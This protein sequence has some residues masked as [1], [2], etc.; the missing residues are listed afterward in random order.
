MHKAFILID[1]TRFYASVATQFAPHLRQVPLVVTTHSAEKG[2]PIALNRA[3]S[4]LGV[5]KFAPL[6]KGDTMRR[7]R[8]NNALIVSANFDTFGHASQRFMQSAIA[9]AGSNV[10]DGKIQHM[11]YSVDE[12][13]VSVDVSYSSAIPWDSYAAEIR[14]RVWREQRIGS[15]V[16]IA[17]TLTLS[18]S[19]SFA[20]KKMDGFAGTCVI[21]DAHSDLCRHILERQPIGDVWNVGQRTAKKLLAKGIQTAAD[22]REWDLK[23]IQSEFGINVANVVSELNGFPV[24]QLDYSQNLVAQR[25]RNEQINSTKSYKDRLKTR[26]IIEAQLAFHCEEVGK[27]ARSQGAKISELHAFSM[28]SRHDTKTEAFYGECSMRFEPTSDSAVLLSQLSRAYRKLVPSNPLAQPI[29]KLGVGATK[30][31]TSDGSDRQFDLFSSE[32]ESRESLMST[33]DE[34]NNRFGH[35]IRFARS[36][37]TSE[38]LESDVG[39]RIPH[40]YTR[41]DEIPIFET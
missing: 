9:A 21:D 36:D 14:K 28:T 16:A 35:V 33:L 1:A 11:V 22:L 30:L 37:W 15:G 10:G 40:M 27:K 6:W 12:V 3:A 25:S 23:A 31:S 18:K 8:S 34:L 7:L 39:A 17:P 32:S 38:Q 41:I 29:Y 2:V 19:A 4:D 20:A 13:F 26:V 5:S 24:Y